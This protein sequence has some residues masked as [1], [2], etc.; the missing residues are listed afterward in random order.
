MTTNTRKK[1]VGVSSLV[2]L[3][4]IRILVLGYD[5]FTFPIYFM[6]QK[7]WIAYMAGR[8]KRAT[9]IARSESSITIMP[10]IKTTPNLDR[11]KAANIKTMDECFRYAVNRFSNKQMI[12]TREIFGE[13]DEKHSENS[14][15]VFLNG[16]T[17]IFTGIKYSKKYFSLHRSYE[18]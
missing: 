13:E 3:W 15:I 4:I 9:E 16:T 7:P 10:E 18:L 2:L 1:R 8:R 5:V 11:F 12:G 14:A 6:Y 17:S